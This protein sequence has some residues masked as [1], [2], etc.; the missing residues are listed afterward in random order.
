M[1]RLLSLLVV[2]LVAVAVCAPVAL[3]QQTSFPGEVANPESVPCPEVLP[4][5]QGVPHTGTLYEERRY[6]TQRFEECVAY[7][8]ESTT[9]AP[10]TQLTTSAMPQPIANPSSG[11]DG[12]AAT[13]CACYTLVWSPASP[14]ASLRSSRMSSICRTAEEITSRTRRSLS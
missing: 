1:R 3:A 9:S 4:G 7:C 13:S 5:V 8:K 14:L 12:M 11:H 10:T 6:G 2:S